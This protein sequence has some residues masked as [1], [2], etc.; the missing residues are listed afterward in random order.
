MQGSDYVDYLAEEFPLQT[1]QS[2]AVCFQYICKP[3]SEQPK[4]NC[5]D[6]VCPENYEIFFSDVSILTDPCPPVS[7]DFRFPFL[8]EVSGYVTCI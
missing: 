2:D 7:V 1:Q 6:P 4:E 5:S 8:R 3:P